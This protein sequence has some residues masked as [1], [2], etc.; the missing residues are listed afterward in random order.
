M[1]VQEESAKQRILAAIADE[2][3]RK[4]LA[5]TRGDPVTALYLSKAYGI[6]ITTVYRRIEGLVEAGLIAVVKSSRTADGKWYDL[7]RG[8]LSRID[9]S[10]DSGDVRV[11]IAV[12]E[13]VSDRFTKV[14]TSIPF[15]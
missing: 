14:W 13:S 11:D 8:L 5:F 1:R 4:I 12:N 6:P 7:Y 3:S 15:L 2:Y 10:F 9:V